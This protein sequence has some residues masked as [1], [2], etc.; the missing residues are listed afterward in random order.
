MLIPILTTNELIIIN[1]ILMLSIIWGV[2]VDD[3]D[4]PCMC[5]FGNSE[6]SEVIP[7]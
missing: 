3:V 4:F 7:L 2:N 5:L 6:S 1:E